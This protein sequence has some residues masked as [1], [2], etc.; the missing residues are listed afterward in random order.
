[1]QRQAR[2]V[3]LSATCKPIIQPSN[4][5]KHRSSS[6]WVGLRTRGAQ[7]QNF[8]LNAFLFF[9]FL[10]LAC[11]FLALL[12]AY[13]GYLF[14]YKRAEYLIMSLPVGFLGAVFDS[15]SL[16]V[17]IFIVKR[18]IRSEN[19]FAYIS[20]LS[21]DVLIAILASLWVLFVFMMSGWLVS[22]VLA[23]PETIGSRFPIV[24]GKGRNRFLRPLEPRKPAQHF[25]WAGYGR[26]GVAS[27]IASRPLWP[28]GQS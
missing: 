9:I 28:A 19:T 11:Y 17:T 6:S 22:Y 5:E 2:K 26:L 8:Y 15:L 16:F 25:L 10:N 27:N 21:V 14:G 12:T 20:Y 24:R 7:T 13:P 23:V 3:W 4:T 1:M 18:A